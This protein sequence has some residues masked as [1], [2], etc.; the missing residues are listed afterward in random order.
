MELIGKI[1]RMRYRQGK[2]LREI[3][4]MTGLSRNTV[5]KWLQPESSEAPAAPRYVRGVRRATKLAPFEERVVL[6]LKADAKRAQGAPYGER[7]VHRDQGGR[8]HGR[9]YA[10]DRLHPCL[11]QVGR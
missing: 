6:A 3:A 4:R 10:A 2:K 8:L 1:R 7:V 11:A 9:L 5:R